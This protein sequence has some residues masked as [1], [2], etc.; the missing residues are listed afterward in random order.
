MEA[1]L[2]DNEGRGVFFSE[3]AAGGEAATATAGPSL[4]Q[5]ALARTYLALL[6]RP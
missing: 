5:V 1:E 6:T 2:A 4:A 3:E